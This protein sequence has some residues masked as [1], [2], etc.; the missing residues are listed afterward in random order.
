MIC[1]SLR[2][3]VAVKWFTTTKKKARCSEEQ[4]ELNTSLMFSM[5]KP[6]FSVAKGR[7]DDTCVRYNEEAFAVAK[8]GVLEQKYL[9]F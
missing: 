9:C 8:D 4:D 2:S 3:F 7:E 6:L 1:S 5:A